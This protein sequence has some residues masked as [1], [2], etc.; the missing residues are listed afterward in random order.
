MEFVSYI[1]IGWSVVPALFAHL[2]LPLVRLDR[3]Q[4]TAGLVEG[5]RRG[6]HFLQ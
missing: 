5:I 6:R 1:H 4:P 3:G 2:L